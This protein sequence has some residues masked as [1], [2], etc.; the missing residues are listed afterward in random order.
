[1]RKFLNAVFIE[2]LKMSAYG[3]FVLFFMSSLSPNKKI[4]TSPQEVLA[5]TD[6]LKGMALMQ[7]NREDYYKKID[8]ITGDSNNLSA[9][10]G[11]DPALLSAQKGQETITV[12]ECQRLSQQVQTANRSLAGS[13]GHAQRAVTPA[14]TVSLSNRE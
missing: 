4:P 12:E 6:Q 14:T 1:M 2:G 10:E 9:A 7:G 8:S 5:M 3:V 13:P 11:L